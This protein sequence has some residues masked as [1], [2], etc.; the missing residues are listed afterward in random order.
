MPRFSVPGV[1]LYAGEKY[2]FGTAHNCLALGAGGNLV[3]CEGVTLFPPGCTW[4]SLALACVGIDSFKFMVNG[5]FPS[6][7][8]IKLSKLNL[9]DNITDILTDSRDG[10]VSYNPLLVQLLQELFN[11]WTD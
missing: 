2:L 7:E 5:A 6:N 4:L 8:E 3:R 11:D 10:W 1:V 9:V